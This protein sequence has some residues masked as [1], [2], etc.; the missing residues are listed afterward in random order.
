MNPFW[1][2]VALSFV[3]GGISVTVF[4]VIAE[5]LGSKIGGLIGSIPSIL[6]VT[7]LFLGWTQG[8]SFAVQATRA[9][10]LGLMVCT[11][12]LFIFILTLFKGLK[13]A[14][15]A[16]FAAWFVFALPIGFIQ[17][18]S[19]IG[20]ITIAVAAILVTFYILEHQ[21]KTEFHEKSKK[22][23]T[24]LQLLARALFS[25]GVVASAV[26]I[27]AF[28]GPFWG[29]LFAMFP[30]RLIS[31]MIILAMAQGLKFAQV[32]GKVLLLS[33]SNNIIYAL[34]I[35]FTYPLYR[36]IWGTILSYIVA[37]VWVALLYLFIRKTK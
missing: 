30:A 20:G 16:S 17:Y 5:R 26:T 10:P 12:S 28:A 18:D 23:Y 36:L 7:F 19:W 21:V 3:V 35:F 24:A 22:P 29:G 27:G 25:G 6:F 33:S 13:L 11:I 2:R 14:I 8:I 31:T 32:T 9:I 37:F 15:F 34:A 4:T 1:L